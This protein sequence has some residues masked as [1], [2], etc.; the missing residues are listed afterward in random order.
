MCVSPEA[1]FISKAFLKKCI[2]LKWPHWGCSECTGWKTPNTVL[3]MEEKPRGEKFLMSQQWL[4]PDQKETTRY[5]Q[6]S[7]K[8]GRHQELLA[9]TS[10]G[11]EDLCVTLN[12]NLGLSQW[13][14]WK[15]SRGIHCSV[16]LR[17]I[18]LCFFFCKSTIPH[19]R[20]YCTI[21]SSDSLWC[22]MIKKTDRL[23]LDLHQGSRKVITIPSRRWCFSLSRISHVLQVCRRVDFIWYGTFTLEA[24]NVCR[25]GIWIVQKSWRRKHGFITHST[26]NT[27]SN[28]LFGPQ[29]SYF[30]LKWLVHIHLNIFNTKFT[31]VA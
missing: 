12:R 11:L 26:N 19:I 5:L 18:S 15:Q 1:Q 3:Y 2:M 24:K 6:H 9:L 27:L 25:N 21:D 8:I 30:Y 22:S 14:V 20:P 23:V 13:L 29:Y 7:I 10:R 28:D 16:Y 17:N 4:I 31:S